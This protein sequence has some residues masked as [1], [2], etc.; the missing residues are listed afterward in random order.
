MSTA[1][2]I[3]LVLGVIVN[4]GQP[5]GVAAASLA[6]ILCGRPG[7]LPTDYERLADDRQEVLDALLEGPQAAA[8][9][10]PAKLEIWRNWSM[11]CVAVPR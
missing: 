11:E 2:I 4:C 1:V 7:P 5:A 3:A 9:V 10:C 6:N 8:R